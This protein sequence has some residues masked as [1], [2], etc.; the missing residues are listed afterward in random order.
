MLL[1]GNF[2]YLH[3]GGILTVRKKNV[4]RRNSYVIK[5]PLYKS[6]SDTC[7]RMRYRNSMPNGRFTV[8][9]WTLNHTYVYK[10]SDQRTTKWAN[11]TIPVPNGQIFRV[12]LRVTLGKSLK[13]KIGDLA[14]DGIRKAPCFVGKISS[15]A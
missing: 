9:M 10:F 6:L 8:S 3:V 2:V 1:S 12:V 5:S 13:W 14:I 11:A 4:T 7:L 15:Y